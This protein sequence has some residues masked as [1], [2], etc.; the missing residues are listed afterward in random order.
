MQRVYTLGS[1]PEY[2]HS[3]V[4]SMRRFIARRGIPEVMRSDNGSNFVGGNK[5]LREAISDW[6]ES[7]IHEFLLQRNI[8]WLFNPPSGS[9]FGGV[10]NCQKDSRCTYEGTAAG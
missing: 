4:N 5:E 1:P 10:W 2:G 7:Q 8:K 3:F 6:N 9:H